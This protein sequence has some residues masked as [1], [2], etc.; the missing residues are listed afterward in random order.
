MD[1]T[2]ISNVLAD[3]EDRLE[4]QRS[5]REKRLTAELNQKGIS[6]SAVIP[7]VEADPEWAEFKAEI[8]RGFIEKMAEWVK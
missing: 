2:A 7:N 4:K 8:H 5:E 6:G 3:L 1:T